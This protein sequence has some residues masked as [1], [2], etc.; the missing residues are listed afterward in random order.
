[1]SKAF[2]KFLYGFGSIIDIFGIAESLPLSKGGFAG[3]QKK[4]QR[5]F[6]NV[7]KDFTKVVN[8]KQQN[9]TKR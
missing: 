8:G 3:D 1:M 7:S 4:L 6:G 2:E 9:Q 5:D